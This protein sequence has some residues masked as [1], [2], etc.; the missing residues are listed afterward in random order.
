RVIGMTM[1]QMK[2]SINGPGSMDRI[3]PGPKNNHK[4]PGSS[5]NCTS[6]ST[7]AAASRLWAS[8]FAKPAKTM[9]D[10]IQGVSKTQSTPTRTTCSCATI[11]EMHHTMTGTT[12]K[13][14]TNT[15]AMNFQSLNAPVTLAKGIPRKVT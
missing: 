12:T 14:S 8:P 9:T 7:G 6:V 11:R 5:I 4:Y 1:I 15:E 3:N 10:S 2:V 13:L